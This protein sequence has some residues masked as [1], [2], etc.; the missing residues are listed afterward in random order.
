MRFKRGM[1]LIEVMIAMSL[2]AG[3]SLYV[4]QIQKNMNQVTNRLEAKV[5]EAQFLAQIQ[6]LVMNPVS[7]TRTLGTYCPGYVG[8]KNS[9]DTCGSSFKFGL[10]FKK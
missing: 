4:A 9:P 7:C 2:M 1:S 3:L 8:R 10:D 6:Q 5:D